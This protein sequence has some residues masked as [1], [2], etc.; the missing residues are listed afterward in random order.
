MRIIILI[1]FIEPNKKGYSTSILL[2][3]KTGFCE[4]QEYGTSLRIIFNR[5]RNPVAIG[6]DI[7]K[8]EDDDACC[9]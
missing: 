4:E 5:D 9:S 1:I 8:S 3:L 6:W 7:G 2:R